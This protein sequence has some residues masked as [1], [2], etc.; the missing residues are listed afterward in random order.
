M[1]VRVRRAKQGLLKI[2]R[3]HRWVVAIRDRKWD[4][5]F[6]DR[7]NRASNSETAGTDSPTR[8]SLCIQD[9]PGKGQSRIQQWS[10]SIVPSGLSVVLS[11]FCCYACSISIHSSRRAKPLMFYL[12]LRVFVCF[13]QNRV[14]WGEV[15]INCQSLGDFNNEHRERWDDSAMKQVLR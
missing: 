2:G 15:A 3:L 7:G 13:I 11:H 5:L 14:L 1:H 8:P 12:A 6:V 4:L 10:S 9:S